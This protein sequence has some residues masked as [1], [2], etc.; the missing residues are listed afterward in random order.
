MAKK[1][2]VT[3]ELLR[4]FEQQLKEQSNRLGSIENNMNKLLNG[5][6][7]FDDPVAQ[8]FRAQY[9]ERMEPL[10]TKLLPAMEKY[11]NFLRIAAEKAERYSQ[12]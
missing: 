7:L 9:T 10:R 6:F 3:A 2:Q 5:G 11:Q 8:R 1:T 12:S 4:N